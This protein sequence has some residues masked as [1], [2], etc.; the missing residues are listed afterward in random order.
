ME[1]YTGAWVV[2]QCGIC[3]ER[4]HRAFHS[5]QAVIRWEY[6]NLN[7]NYVHIA[8]L[9]SLSFQ[10]CLFAVL[11]TSVCGKWNL[12]WNL[13][14]VRRLCCLIHVNQGKHSSGVSHR[15]RHPHYPTALYKHKSSLLTRY[16]ELV[17]IQLTYGRVYECHLW[18]IWGAISR[19]KRLFLTMQRER[20]FI[21]WG[22]N[23]CLVA[24][25]R[26][27]VWQGIGK[28]LFNLLAWWP[29][30]GLHHA[31]SLPPFF[32]LPLRCQDDGSCW[33]LEFKKRKGKKTTHFWGCCML[34]FSIMM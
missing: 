25:R 22:C 16:R 4:E 9:L 31:V 19:S 26:L 1:L 18:G 7:L 12:M 29:S 14:R 30:V 33:L 8:L 21:E 17:N 15:R 6:S 23:G 11:Y 10:S 24:Q 20:C 3:M 28:M 5:T 27:N 2:L 32:F 34:F 13:I